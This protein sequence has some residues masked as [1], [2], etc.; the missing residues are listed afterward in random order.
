M[1]YGQGAR[2][3]DAVGLG[4]HSDHTARPG[5]HIADAIG[6]GEGSWCPCSWVREL[7]WRYS[8]AGARSVD[9]IGS[10][11]HGADAVGSGGHGVAAIGS[12]GHQSPVHLLQI[13]LHPFII[14]SPRSGTDEGPLML[15]YRGG[16]SHAVVQAKGL[17]CCATG[18]GPLMLWYRGGA[19]HAVVQGRGL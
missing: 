19:S 10:G 2:K 5:A 11:A 14:I 3:D 9:T 17:S 18:E 13:R 1:Q 4:A 7:L 16:A 6:S 8:T 12:G 15:W